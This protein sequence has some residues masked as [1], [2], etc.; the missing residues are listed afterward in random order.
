MLSY[1]S[2][3]IYDPNGYSLRGYRKFFGYQKYVDQ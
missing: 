1:E 2:Q 3:R